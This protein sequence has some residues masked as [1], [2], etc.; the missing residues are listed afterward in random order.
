[1]KDNSPQ[2]IASDLRI[3]NV[4]Q[5]MFHSPHTV[6]AIGLDSVGV[7]VTGMDETTNKK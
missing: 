4:I 7:G 6:L 2:L 5:G 1:M 3:G